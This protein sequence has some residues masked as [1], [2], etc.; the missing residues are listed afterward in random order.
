MRIITAVLSINDT[1]DPPTAGLTVEVDGHPPVLQSDDVNPKDLVATLDAVSGVV[2][3]DVA[4]LVADRFD[5]VVAQLEQTVAAGAEKQQ[6]RE[7]ALT[8]WQD[9]T[10]I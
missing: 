7:Q 4:A 1:A 2:G 5:G 8:A 3:V 6:Q 10:S 9:A